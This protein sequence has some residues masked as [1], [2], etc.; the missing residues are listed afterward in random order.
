MLV[1]LKRDGTKEQFDV[2]KI[3]N[4]VN[5]ACDGLPVN[6]VELEAKFDQFISNE[7]TTE[8]IHDNLI[9]HAKSW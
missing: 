2:T 7:I 3:R 6:P 1:V 9:Y 4:V 8:Q 5:M